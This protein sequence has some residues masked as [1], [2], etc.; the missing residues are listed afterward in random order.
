M[1]ALLEKSFGNLMRVSFALT[2]MGFYTIAI[3]T[4]GVL[5]PQYPICIECV[6]RQHMLRNLCRVSTSIIVHS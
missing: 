4:D 2:E 5:L 6:R 1:P 3:I